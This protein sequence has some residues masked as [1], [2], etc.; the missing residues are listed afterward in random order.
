MVCL[1]TMSPP[2]GNAEVMLHFC[3]TLFHNKRNKCFEWREN[4]YFFMCKITILDGNEWGLCFNP[5]LI[6]SEVWRINHR[7]FKLDQWLS[8]GRNNL[9]W[10]CSLFSPHHVKDSLKP[11]NDICSSDA[12]GKFHFVLWSF[13]VFVCTPFICLA[14]SLTCHFLS[15]PF[16]LSLCFTFPSFLHSYPPFLSSAF[17]DFT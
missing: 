6:F 3:C 14:C 13:S 12:G 1:S 5:A 16:A 15:L 2:G 10:L 4:W 11:V 7:D 8:L 9:W 17:T